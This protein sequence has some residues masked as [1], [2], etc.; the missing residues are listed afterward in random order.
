MMAEHGDVDD[1][2]SS[3]RT[4]LGSENCALYSDGDEDCGIDLG[5]KKNPRK[6]TTWSK[7]SRTTEQCDKSGK[8]SAGICESSNE[9]NPRDSGARSAEKSNYTTK[10]ID[11][12]EI[13]QCCLC[14]I[15]CLTKAALDSHTEKIHSGARRVCQ[16]CRK[17]YVEGGLIRHLVDEH[18]SPCETYEE[19]ACSMWD[20]GMNA[21]DRDIDLLVRILGMDRLMSM[22]NYRVSDES[23]INCPTCEMYFS[24][25]HMYRF[26]LLMNHDTMCVLCNIEFK[27]GEDAAKHKKEEHR[28]T[29]CYIWFVD[30]ILRNLT[31]VKDFQ[32]IVERSFIEIISRDSADSD[33]DN[34]DSFE[35]KESKFSDDCSK[36]IMEVENKGET[37]LEENDSLSEDLKV[38]AEN[39]DKEDMKIMLVVT[40]DDLDKYDIGKRYPNIWGLASKI[41]ST[42]EEFTPKDIKEMLDTYFEN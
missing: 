7:V 37:E 3:D 14:R 8:R 20:V 39:D 11:E 31:A 2:D 19:K 15:Y 28:S 13:H 21:M 29:S 42:C 33:E 22:W 38:K 25:K 24:S 5:L 10:Y 23:S 41:S 34:R 18:I 16:L 4:L 35:T 9:T 1:E 6:L 17:M 32:K 12:R 30:R 40:D 27:S 26:H 36:T